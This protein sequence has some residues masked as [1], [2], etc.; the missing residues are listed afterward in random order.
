MVKKK[1]ERDMCD[2]CKCMLIFYIRNLLLFPKGN[3]QND[4]VSIYLEL[5]SLHEEQHKQD[6]DF[7]ACAQFLIC[8][9]DPNDPTHYATHGKIH[10]YKNGFLF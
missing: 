4:V 10:L 3:N 7:H 5:A 9:S 2:L 8:I 1:R 6:E